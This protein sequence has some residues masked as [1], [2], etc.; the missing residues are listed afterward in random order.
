MISP[1][2]S[3]V[4]NPVHKLDEKTPES[5]KIHTGFLG[6]EYLPILFLFF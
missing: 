1:F 4:D 6:K 2:V 3:L 5:V